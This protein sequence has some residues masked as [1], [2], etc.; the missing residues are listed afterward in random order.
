MAV[1][2]RPGIAT[3]NGDDELRDVGLT[4]AV[5]RTVLTMLAASLVSSALVAAPVAAAP[6]SAVLVNAADGSVLYAD[7]ADLMRAP[8]SLTKMMT[9]FLT[10]DALDAGRLRLSDRVVMSRHAAGQAPSKLGLAPGQSLSVDEAIR[11][12]AVQSANDVSVALAEKLAGN[13]PAFARAMT[14]RARSLGMRRTSFVNAS[15]L[16]NRGNVTTAQDIAI[17]S[18]AMLRDHP[19]QY[20]YFST[21]S[22]QWGN[23]RVANHNHLLG[24]VAGVDGIKTGYTA[25][26]GFNLA[27]SA[28]RGGTRLIAVVMG[29]RSIRARDQ[30]VARLLE[31]GFASVARGRGQSS[32]AVATLIRD[33]VQRRTPR[34]RSG[35]G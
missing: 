31:V 24:A 21:R 26:A 8:A 28:K 32:A 15:G 34:G 22:F 3:L 2:R 7:S 4:G 1:P 11:V 12:I 16:R 25:D 30:R 14:A 29:E 13:E 5:R 9:L 35:G 18:V 10:F 17:L 27:A 33:E 23:R 6:V 19:R 20:G